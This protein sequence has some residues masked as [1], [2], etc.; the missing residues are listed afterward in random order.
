MNT[1][2]VLT[3]VAAAA[4]AA[5]A[6]TSFA[7]PAAS[8]SRI[9]VNAETQAA[10]AAHTL[11]PAGQ[12]YMG[13]DPTN[14]G[15]STKTRAQ[16]TAETREVASAHGLA[17]AGEHVDMSDQHTQSDWA[18]AEPSVQTDEAMQAAARTPAGEG[19]TAP[20]K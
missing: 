5:L 1:K 17:P 19:P 14:A 9:D 10:E 16:V 13:A 4:F 2:H 3:V 8:A 18:R 20:R 7:Y 11:I 15:A 12:G 6:Q